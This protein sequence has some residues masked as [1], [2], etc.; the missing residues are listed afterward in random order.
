MIRRGNRQVGSKRLK[1]RN[2]TIIGEGVRTE[3]WYFD[4]LHDLTGLPIKVK[5]RNFGINTIA[6]FEKKIKQIREKNDDVIIVVFDTD[7]MR[8]KEAEWRRLQALKKTYEK[9][10]DVLICDSYPC[11]EYWFLLHYT[12]TNKSY[13]APPNSPL[14]DQ[15]EEDLRSYMP[16]YSKQDKWVK[17]SHWVAALRAEGREQAARD[18][19][20]KY[21]EG[22]PLYEKGRSYTNIYKFFERYLPEF[23]EKYLPKK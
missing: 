21:K 19:A 1:T 20:L 13:T 17:D 7:V 12:D 2:L 14:S 8:G 5:D 9:S 11:I 22:G 6:A 10:E 18:R 4:H 16:A 3:R 23:F 15:V